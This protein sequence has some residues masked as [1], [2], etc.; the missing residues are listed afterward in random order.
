MRIARTGAVADPVRRLLARAV[1]SLG[2]G[3]LFVWLLSARLNGVDPAEVGRALSGVPVLQW[4]LALAAT[5]ASFRA[6]GRYDAVVHRHLATGIAPAVARRAG[7]CAIAVSQM[8][9]MGVVTGTVLR[10]RMLPGQS[11]ALAARLTVAVALSFLAGW[12]VV[13]ASVLLILPAAPFKPLA[14]LAVAVA[15]AV[16]LATLVWPHRTRRWPNLFTQTRLVGLAAVDTGAAAL[17]LYMLLP[18]ETG[19]GFPALLPVFLL[20]QG[21]GLLSGAPGGVGAFEVTFLALL[22]EAPQEPLLAA[23]LAWRVIYY[24]LPA[25]LAGLAAALGP[26]PAPA[27]QPRPAAP[28]APGRAETGIAAQGEHRWLASGDWLAGRTAH[29]L[30]GM[31]DPIAPA[32]DAL[33]NL[34]AA[35]ACADRWPAIYKCTG[36]T[37]A[38]ARAEGWQVAAIAREAGLDPRGFELTGA[39]RSALRRKLRRA[40]AAGVQ[41]VQGAQGGPLPL[42]AMG[43]LAAE[44]ASDRGGERGFSMGRFAAH[45]V[46]GQQVFLAWCAGRLVGFASFHHGPREWVLDLM[47]NSPDA[48]DGTMHALV[49]AGIAE[50][51]RQRV[52]RLSLAAVPEAAFGLSRPTDRMLARLGCDGAGLLQFKTAFAPAWQPLYLAA[53]HR[54]ALAL[55]ACEIARAIARPSPLP[56]G[57][58]DHAEYGFASAGS[59]WHRRGERPLPTRGSDV[60]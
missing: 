39:G 49:A 27:T 28:T 40:G 58:Q 29:V 33:R 56:Q 6:V 48:P 14:L 42:P 17:A 15:G 50:A 10:L 8:L 23:I 21:A 13:T 32:A 18:A 16:M 34:S 41:V 12:A 35:A 31:F 22:P 19:L 44:W 11:P 54:P 38:L 26:A 57:E 5:A 3:G 53:P 36:R 37:A 30:V 51:G 55:A 24:A 52:P 25:V 7:I 45:Y 9:G 59:A 60:R 46:S 2:L 43:R 20:A 4:A 1:L 47:R